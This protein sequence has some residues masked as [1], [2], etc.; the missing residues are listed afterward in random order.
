MEERRQYHRYL[1][2]T[3]IEHEDVASHKKQRSLSKDISRGGVCVTTTGGP[4][5][6]GSKY[7]L[8]FVLPFSEKE[9]LVAAEVMWAKHE[10]NVYDNG[11]VFLEIDKEYL[12]LIEEFSIGSI[13]EKESP[14][15]K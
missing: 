1:L 4:L 7:Q 11:L 6:K 5:E 13:E 15:G 8:K 14:A 9:I 10:G 12:D 3:E 2:H